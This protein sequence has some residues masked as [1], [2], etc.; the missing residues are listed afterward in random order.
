MTDAGTPHEPTRPPAGW[1][2]SERPGYERWWD[3]VSWTEMERP[4]QLPLSQ[5]SGQQQFAPSTGGGVLV[6]DQRTSG[7][8]IT[9]AWILTVLTLGYLL[10]WAIA[11]TRGKSNSV[12]VG[13]LN[14]LLGWTVIGWVIALVMACTAH[15]QVLTHR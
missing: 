7:I 3:G 1:Y 11:A 12:A 2:P 14:L 4:A 9:F 10:P 6:T 13:V 15:R 5:P 8:E